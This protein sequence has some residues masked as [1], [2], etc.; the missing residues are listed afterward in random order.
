MKERKQT[1]TVRPIPG[2]PARLLENAVDKKGSEK[3]KA[4]D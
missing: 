4:A 1:A 3:D 2:N